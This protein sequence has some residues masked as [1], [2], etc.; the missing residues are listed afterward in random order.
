MAEGVQS[1]AKTFYQMGS[2][3]IWA[4]LMLSAPKPAV[5]E[6]LI[7]FAFGER[8]GVEDGW[9]NKKLCH[10]PVCQ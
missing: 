6:S 9:L 7:R 2:I 5:K 8:A 3:R 1:A 10:Q 4:L